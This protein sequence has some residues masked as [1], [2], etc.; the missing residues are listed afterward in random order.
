MLKEGKEVVAQGRGCQVHRQVGEASLTEERHMQNGEIAIR[1]MNGNGVPNVD[2]RQYQEVAIVAKV[3][4]GELE[5][6][7]VGM[8]VERLGIGT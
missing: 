1:V 8:E 3:S 6:G 7:K 2:K 4:K 5:K